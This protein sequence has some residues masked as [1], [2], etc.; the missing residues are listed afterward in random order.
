MA[1]S[2]YRWEWVVAVVV[3]LL[4]CQSGPTTASITEFLK[5]HYR[6]YE[7]DTE[8]RYSIQECKMVNHSNQSALIA[9]IPLSIQ[10]AEHSNME[11]IP[12]AECVLE[13][14]FHDFPDIGTRG[15]SRF[16]MSFAWLPVKRDWFFIRRDIL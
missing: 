13:F 16:R 7:K 9:E 4:G 15:K 3:P 1:A 11:E 14:E 2:K 12:V 8:D 5:Q 10:R 6:A